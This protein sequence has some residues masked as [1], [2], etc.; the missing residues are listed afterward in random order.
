[1]KRKILSIAF[2]AISALMI[3]AVAKD[4]SDKTPK[5]NNKKEM[6]GCHKGKKG[7]DKHF[8][9]L[10]PFEGIN[11]TD[12]QKS[13]LSNLEQ[14]RKKDGAKKEKSDKDAASRK[15][16]R[17]AR[18]AYLEEV[19]QILTP[20][21]YVTYL[22]NIAINKPMKRKGHGRNNNHGFGYERTAAPLSAPQ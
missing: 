7:A 10:D 3:T 19:K 5:D 17:D 18:K 2:V 6:C 9:K 11:L 15:N 14:N 12:A 20:E 16:K 22:E 4:N 8:A 21:Q 1:M 13:Q